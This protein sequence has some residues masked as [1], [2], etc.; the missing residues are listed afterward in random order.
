[1]IHFGSNCLTNW[2]L[3]AGALSA[4]CSENHGHRPINK[5]VNINI[6][7]AVISFQS[8]EKYCNRWHNCG[9]TLT[10]LQFGA[11]KGNRIESDICYG[12]LW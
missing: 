2:R 3:N 11:F 10:T 9:I 5:I 1:M 8:T 7:I 4:A 12:S 6:I